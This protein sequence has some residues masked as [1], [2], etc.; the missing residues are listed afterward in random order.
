MQEDGQTLGIDR[1]PSWLKPGIIFSDLRVAMM[2]EA[3]AD[4]GRIEKRRGAFWTV[5]KSPRRLSRFG[6]G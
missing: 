3:T 4:S 6:C 2:V 5:W 1:Q